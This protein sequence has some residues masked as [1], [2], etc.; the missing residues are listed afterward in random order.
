MPAKIELTITGM[1]CANCV[2]AVE[3]TLS[4][5]QGIVSAEVNYA[6]EQA[7]VE[8]D[9]AQVAP[10]DVITAIE[11]AGYGATLATALTTETEQSNDSIEI[12]ARK[13]WIGVLLTFPLFL[14][15]MGRDFNLLGHWV[16]TTPVNWLMLLLACPVQFYV[17]GDYYVSAWKSLKNHTANMDVLVV[18]GTSVAFFYSTAVLLHLTHHDHVY[19]ET[20][21]LIIT[22]IK[23]GKLLEARAKRQTQIAIKTLIGLQPKTARV[24]YNDIES[25]IAIDNIKIGDVIVVRPGEKIPVDGEVIAGNSSVNES[26]LTG[27]SLPVSKHPRSSVVGATLNQQGLLKIRATQVGAGTVLA[28]IIQRVQQAQGS[29][30]PIQHLADQVSNIFVPTIIGI[31]ILTFMLWLNTDFSTAM[32]RMVAVLVIACP[33]ALGLA[34]PTAIVVGMGRGAE[35]GILFKNSEALEQAHRLKVIVFDK[36]GTIT[37]GRPTVTD[38]IIHPSILLTENELLRLTASAERGSEHPFGQAIVQLAQQRNLSLSEP[39]HFESIAGGGVMATIENQKMV[40]GH[41]K[42]I[43]ESLKSALPAILETEQSRLQNQAKTVIWISLNQQ[44]IGLM[45][46]ADA[47]KPH[48]KEAMTALQNLGL[49]V[50]ML[51]GDHHATA[52]AIAKEVGITEILAGILP[53]DKAN[54]IKRLQIKHRGLVAMVGDG[55]NDAPA[56]AQADVGI[57]MGNGTDVA[58]ETADVTLMRS[59]LR[60]VAQAIFLSKATMR[61]IKQ[62]LFWAFGY[63]VLLIPIAMGV[64]YPFTTLPTMLRFL[65]P[66]LAAAAMALSS[67]SVVMNS[68]RLKRVK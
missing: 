30:A 18:M 32:M 24:I 46:I 14:L 12:N 41:Q 40:I 25:D 53:T 64:L 59:D 23:L 62:N 35:Q 68:L 57:A 49:Q 50:V 42:F 28:Q 37:T 38:I 67:V 39:Q 58:I 51:T 65:H 44:I 26:M 55:I 61:I 3:R 56:L 1:T 43:T 9:P 27:E 29:K 5:T 22:L 19:F 63:N 47:V 7:T 34:T 66:A 54:E 8:Y 48:A 20:A 2:R 15:S 21:A 45:A 36:T 10:T 17:G 6:T 52:Q 11:R 60:S 31:A 33:C 13:F 16:L 4:K